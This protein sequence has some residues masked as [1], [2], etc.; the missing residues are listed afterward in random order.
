[1]RIKHDQINY[2]TVNRIINGKDVAPV[3]SI[4][5]LLLIAITILITALIIT[6]VTR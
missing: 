2:C 1:M 3:F 5:K 4:E 6:Q